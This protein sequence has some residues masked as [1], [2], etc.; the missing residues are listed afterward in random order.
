MKTMLKSIGLVASFILIASSCTKD[1]ST[2]DCI[3]QSSISNNSCPEVYDPVCGCN[4]FTYSNSC[5]ATNA[6]VKSWTSGPCT[7]DCIGT[8]NPLILCTADYDPVCG[9]D[10]VTYSND[11]MAQAAGIKKWTSGAC[12]TMCDTYG[13]VVQSINWGCGLVIRLDDGHILEP[14]SVPSGFNLVVDQRIKFSYTVMDNVDQTCN[15]ADPIGIDCIEVVNVTTCDSILPL[16]NMPTGMD[17]YLKINAAVITG[18]CLDITVQYAGGCHEQ[19]FDLFQSIPT[20]TPGLT[21][22]DLKLGHD[23]K[24]DLCQA[25]ITKNVSF[26]L[27]GLQVF[28]TNSVTLN[29]T[30]PADPGYTQTLTYTY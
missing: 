22:Y 16:A 21:T 27:S 9:C 4:G 12:N 6:G 13:T 5:F 10:G 3:D 11:C 30:S 29:L 1:D 26:D 23:A 14:M 18:D 24:G 2:D 28:G 7:S 17:D 25:L 15:G 20:P 19:V 8:P